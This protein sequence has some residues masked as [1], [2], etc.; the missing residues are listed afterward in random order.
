MSTTCDRGVDHVLRRRHHGQPVEPVVGHLGHADVGIL[1][2]ERVRR[3]ERAPAGERVVQRGLA[4]VGETDQ[5]EAFHI[6]RLRLL[7]PRV[8]D[9]HAFVATPPDDGTQRVVG[10]GVVGARGA[11][12]RAGRPCR[13]RTRRSRRGAGRTPTPATTPAPAWSCR[14]TPS[15][16][17][18]RR[19]RHLGG[20]VALH[21]RRRPLPARLVHVQPGSAPAGGHAGPAGRPAAAQRPRRR[22]VGVPDLALRRHPGRPHGGRTVGAVPLLRPGSR[23]IDACGRPGVAARSVAGHARLRVGVRRA[24][25]GGEGARRRGGAVLVAVHVGGHARRRHSDGDG[26][27]GRR[28]GA[29]RADHLARRGRA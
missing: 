20:A 17:V 9:P 16:G 24:A 8:S 19:Q 22:E 10:D 4:R 28:R 11:G 2:R 18:V 27:L 5:T 21:R 3:G 15:G 26:A 13:V 1:R 25:A 23:R 7:A 14:S 29:R 12:V 6:E